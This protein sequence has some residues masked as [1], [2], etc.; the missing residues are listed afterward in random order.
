ME[1]DR[2]HAR[3]P[4]GGQ[5]GRRPT[6]EAIAIFV[7]VAALLAFLRVR[8]RLEEQMDLGSIFDEK[9]RSWLAAWAIYSSLFAYNTFVLRFS[10]L[11][12]STWGYVWRSSTIAM[13]GNLLVDGLEALAPWDVGRVDYLFVLLISPWILTWIMLRIEDSRRPQ[14]LKQ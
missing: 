5:Q 9:W 1:K 11:R 6:F 7:V 3:Q 10:A 2:S 13:I 4:T 12:L 8:V 14:W